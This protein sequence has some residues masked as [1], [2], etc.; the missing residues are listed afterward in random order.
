MGLIFADGIILPLTAILF[1]YFS[2]RTQKHWRLTFLF[3]GVQYL[4]ERIYLALGYLQYVNWNIWISMSIYFLGFRIAAHF[5]R[6]M[7][8]YSPPISYS[9]RIATFTYTINAW[10]GAI[11]GG[12]LLGLWQW[13]PH[14][15][16]EKGADERFSDSAIETSLG[17]MSAFI[18]P[19][20]SAK[21]RMWV[22]MLFALI[23]STICYLA[24]WKGWFLYRH[25]NHFLSAMRWIVP[26]CVI[27]LYDRWENK[28][29][30]EGS[31][32]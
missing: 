10:I 18:I 17:I 11:L 8:L 30:R 15:F 6:R 25:W 21:H 12:A 4:L 29:Q 32:S 3:T 28:P 22:F 19:R 13:R 5:A 24:Y 26:S 14:I 23:A 2:S 16:G 1:C 31:L 9:I 27:S 7:L 20:I